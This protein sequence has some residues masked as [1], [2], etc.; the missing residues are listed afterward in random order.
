MVLYVQYVITQGIN[1][2]WLQQRTNDLQATKMLKKHFA[3]MSFYTE[4]TDR[5]P[6]GS[7]CLKA[8]TFTAM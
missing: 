3:E 2:I 1:I 4:V 7:T 8:C 6:W 5:L